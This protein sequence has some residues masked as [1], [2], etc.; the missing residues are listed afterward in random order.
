VGDK[1]AVMVRIKVDKK[2]AKAKV[3]KIRMAWLAGNGAD[4]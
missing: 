4:M 2:Y 3:T 1:V